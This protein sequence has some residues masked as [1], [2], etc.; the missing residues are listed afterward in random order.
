M[1][2]KDIPKLKSYI[3]TDDGQ[4]IDIANIKSFTPEFEEEQSAMECIFALSTSGIKDSDGLYT[5]EIRGTGEKIVRC[6]NCKHA[7]PFVSINGTVNE[8]ACK[9]LYNSVV[10][11]MP[12]NGFCS[13]GKEGCV[14]R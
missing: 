2:P 1:P 6:R 9:R 4:V 13:Y 12:K 5:V 11:I 14:R 8:Y 10:T 7:H 3:K